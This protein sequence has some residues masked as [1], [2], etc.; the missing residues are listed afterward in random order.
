MASVRI[1]VLEL[2]TATTP[3]PC[4]PNKPMDA[5]VGTAVQPRSVQ[6]PFAAARM[7]CSQSILPLSPSRRLRTTGSTRAASQATPIRELSYNVSAA[8]L[9][10]ETD[11]TGPADLGYLDAEAYRLSVP[12]DGGS[13]Q[14]TSYTALGALRGLQT[15]Q[16]LIYTLPPKRD[17]AGAAPKFIRNVP[18]A[19]EDRPAYPYRGLLLDTARNW[20]DLATIRKLST[21]WASSSSTSST[22]SATDTQSFPLALDDDADAQGGKGSQL[23]L[24]AER[25]S[26]GWTKVDG[27]NTRMVYTET[28][29]R[30]IVEYAARRGVNVIIE[31]DMPAHMLSGVEAIDDGSL[32]AC[33]NEQAWENVAAEPP[34][35]QLRLFTNTKASPAP[36]AAT[37]KVPD[38]INRFV[39]SL[40]RKIATLSKSVY[41]SSGGDEPNFKCWNLT[42]EA[43]MEPYIAPFMQLVTNLTD[44]SGKRG[45]VWEE[46]AVKFPKVAKTLAPNSLVEI[47]NDANNS[48]VALTNNPDVNIVLAPYSYFYLDCGSASFLGNYTSNTWCPYVSWQQ[49]YSFDPPATIAN[50]TGGGSGR[51]SRAQQVC[52]WRTCGLDRDHRSHQPRE[53]SLATCSCGRRGLVDRR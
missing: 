32:M 7:P 53:Q 17:D 30:G 3:N 52:R 29:V 45:M 24:L 37:Y 35:G 18:I 50:A 41:V 43:E 34:S 31:T 8:K 19:I 4:V 39:S 2:M 20:F 5:A 21:P 36:D 51:Q 11:K 12:A 26:Y 10:L 47:W 15:L 13:I 33:P 42:T 25:G 46:M 40:L 48:R 16:Q 23:S 22:G 49:T 14:L 28:D 6:Q 27:K 44:A 1:S 9:N 38:N